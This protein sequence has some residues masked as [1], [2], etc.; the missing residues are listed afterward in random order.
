ME[1]Q[2]IIAE[3]PNN[4]DVNRLIFYCNNEPDNPIQEYEIILL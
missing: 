1:L 3:F 4:N 2:E